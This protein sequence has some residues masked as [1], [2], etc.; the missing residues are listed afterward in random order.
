MNEIFN[1]NSSWFQVEQVLFLLVFS[2]DAC[3]KLILRF[4]D[5]HAY[6]QSPIHANGDPIASIGISTPC[7]AIEKDMAIGKNFSDDIFAHDGDAST[8]F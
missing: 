3:R 1:L 5:L 6:D 8:V 2:F 4:C 7:D